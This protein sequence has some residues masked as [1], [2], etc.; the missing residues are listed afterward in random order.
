MK[1]YNSFLVA[2]IAF[3]T[4]WFFV[5]VLYIGAFLFIPFSLALL[6][7]FIILSLA[8]FFQDY[9]VPSIISYILSLGVI[10]FVIYI[11]GQIITTNINKLILDAP[12]YEQKLVGIIGDLAVKFRIDP[13]MLRS[14]FV[15]SVDIPSIASYTASIITGIVKYAGIIFFFTLFIIL[16]STSFAKKLELITGGRKSQFFIIFEQIKSDVKLFFWVKTL[17][18]LLWSGISFVIMFL[19]QVEFLLFWTFLIFILNFIPTFGSIIAVLLPVTFYLIQY[20]SFPLTIV[21]LGLLW[22]AQGISWNFIEMKLMGDRLNLSPLVILISLIFW[23][24]LWGPIGMLLCIPIMVMINIVLA[25]IEVTRP[26]AVFLSEKW[27]VVFPG[28]QEAKDKLS[29]KKMK[30]FLKGE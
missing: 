27:V 1:K 4:L 13:E 21:L 14:Q 22:W 16:E 24:T 6:L 7:S 23:G 20:E 26:I 2:C 15:Q 11:I 17:V 18:S 3:L 29:L 28:M 19:F 10:L 25:H 8:N 12:N 30:K 5:Y 9:K